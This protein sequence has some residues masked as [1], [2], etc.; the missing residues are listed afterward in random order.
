MRA[1]AWT[2]P[3]ASSFSK[4][5]SKKR[6]GSTPSCTKTAEPA[7]GAAILG[8]AAA[9]IGFLS[10]IALGL[11][12]LLLVTG[13]LADDHGR[14]RVFVIGAV[15]LTLASVV[16]AATPD[17]LVFVA[18]RIAQGGAGAALP[19]AGLGLVG[20]VFPAGPR[21][22]RATGVWGAMVGGGVALGGHGR[23][24]GLAVVVLAGG[25]RIRAAGGDR[26]GDAHRVPCRT[27]PAP[28]RTRCAATRSRR[29]FC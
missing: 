17:S 7:D 21:R 23:A 1:S 13:S 2:P 19:A 28:G 15:A 14:K 3:A 11:A 22:A 25:R 26:G 20:S 18:G 24:R 4:T 6:I 27:V 8:L 5:S 9:L 10:G 16:C 12:V 29:A